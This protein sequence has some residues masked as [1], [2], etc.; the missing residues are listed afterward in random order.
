MPSEP[1]VQVHSNRWASDSSILSDVTDTDPVREAIDDWNWLW[2]RC[3]WNATVLAATSATASSAHSGTSDH[4]RE[5]SLSG[6][7]ESRAVAR[8]STPTTPAMAPRK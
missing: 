5:T 6:R 2:K 3:H 4:C 1:F 7:S 8:P